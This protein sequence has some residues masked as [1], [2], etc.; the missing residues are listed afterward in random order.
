M[1]DKD[2][3]IVIKKIKKGGHGH[4]GGAWKVAYADFVTAMMA[5]FLLMWL[6]T[7][8]P[9]ENLQGLADYFTPTQGLQGKMGIGF[10]GG[11]S[12]NTDGVSQ[13]DWASQGLIFGAPPS[14]PIIKNP[15]ID[16]KIDTNNQIVNQ[17]AVTNTIGEDQNEQ[18]VKDKIQFALVNSSEIK[19]FE[20]SVLLESSPEGIKIQ[21]MD[22]K[23][24]PMFAKGTSDLLPHSKQ[25]I[26]KI[27]DVIRVIPNYI[28]ITGHT[29]LELEPDIMNEYTNWE[30]SSDRANAARKHLIDS[31]MDK[32]QIARIMGKADHDPIDRSSPLANE[33]Q[34]ITITLLRKSL[35]SNHKKSAPDEIL[36]GP[37]EDG[38]ESYIKNRKKIRVNRNFEGYNEKNNPNSESIL[39]KDKP[40]KKIENPYVK[41]E[42]DVAKPVEDANNEEKDPAENKPEMIEDASKSIESKAE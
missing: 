20:D 10:S 8:T 4:H 41:K 1:A 33:N 40:I 22:K 6:L 7:A 26:A 42:V 39:N 24:R 5:F 16:N 31:G 35:L 14:G 19:E 11:K 18:N 29:V 34:R 9:V 30:L 21:I 36:L 27:A 37:T 28:Q 3:T 32:E 17:I 13:G 12:P 15:D 25:I 2:Q 23:G 38:L